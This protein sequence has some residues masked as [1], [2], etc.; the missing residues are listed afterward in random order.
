MDIYQSDLRELDP[1]L[2]RLESE[3][4]IS[5]DVLLCGTGWLPS[6]DFFDKDL[7][8]KLD[9][10]HAVEDDPAQYSEKWATLEKEADQKVIQRFPLLADP[11]AHYTKPRNITPYRLYKGI[12][13]VSDDSIVFIGHVLVGNYFS[14]TETQ[15]IWAT[16]YLDKKFALPSLAERE[17]EIALFTAWCRRRYLN[18]GQNGNWMTFEFIVYNDRLLHQVGLSSNRKGWFKNLFSPCMARDMAGLRDEYVA[19]YGKDAT[20]SHERRLGLV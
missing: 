18:N 20:A 15:A 1:G 12:A 6:L 17:T 4:V 8:I 13:P 19:K 7:L 14:V 11:P 5:T 9:L 10:P 16:A 2:V 3:E